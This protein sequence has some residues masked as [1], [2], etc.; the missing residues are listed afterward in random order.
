MPNKSGLQK[1]EVMTA[2]KD[3][4]TLKF[5]WVHM[6]G[7]IC[8]CVEANLRFINRNQIQHLSECVPVCFFSD[9]VSSVILPQPG[10]QSDPKHP[11]INDV[12]VASKETE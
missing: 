7:H 6:C 8:C 11:I 5:V 3:V 2:V 1:T 4:V 9:P 12:L 10:S